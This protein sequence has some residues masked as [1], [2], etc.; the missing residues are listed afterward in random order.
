[1]SRPY[2]EDIKL[3]PHPVQ[4]LDPGSDYLIWFDRNLFNRG[5]KK[6]V[7]ERIFSL[8]HSA[9]DAN[10]QLPNG[11]QTWASLMIS[12]QLFS[13]LFSQN[14]LA[15]CR[16]EILLQIAEKLV[17]NTIE[18]ESESQM[19]SYIKEV[20][21]DEKMASLANIRGGPSY[22]SNNKVLAAGMPTQSQL[23]QLLSNCTIY[24]VSQEK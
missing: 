16:L 23:Q 13:K 9:P 22:V 12:T 11:L 7:A 17:L 14:G 21:H 1:L 19:D 20:I 4:I 3:K 6:S 8:F 15:I 24:Y 5:Q 2:L 18:L 10:M